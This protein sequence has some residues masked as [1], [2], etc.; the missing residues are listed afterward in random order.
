M[1]IPSMETVKRSLMRA[2]IAGL[3][4][5]ISAFAILPINLEN[6]KTY[7]ITLGIAMLSGFLMGLQ[8]F[9]SGWVKYD[10]K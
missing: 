4:G 3:V 8:K 10:N 2:G 6:S 1:T 7:F 5:A 9:V